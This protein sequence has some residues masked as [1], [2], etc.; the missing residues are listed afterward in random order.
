[1]PLNTS[2]TTGLYGLTGEDVTIDGVQEVELFATN[3]T[4]G[5]LDQTWLYGITDVLADTTNP[6][7]ES[8]TMLA[9]APADSNF[10][11]VAFAPAAAPEASTWVMMLTGFAGLGFAAR[12]RLRA[13]AKARLS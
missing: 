9:M 2:G 5:D 10:K 8:F 4:I 1:N 7:D 12:R 3:A 6:G 11:G 13:T